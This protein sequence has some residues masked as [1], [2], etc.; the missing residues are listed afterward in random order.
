MSKFKKLWDEAVASGSYRE[1]MDQIEGLDHTITVSGMYRLALAK[2]M[3]ER[4][5]RA[6]FPRD[7]AHTFARDMAVA[8]LPPNVIPL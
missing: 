1:H 6:E 7:G 2:G 3:T 4:E 8:R 5:I